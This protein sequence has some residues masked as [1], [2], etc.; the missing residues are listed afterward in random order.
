MATP[1]IETTPTPVF[2]LYPHQIHVDFLLHTVKRTRGGS[3]LQAL[4]SGK[5]LV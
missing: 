3:A 1:E 5:I 2:V 4:D